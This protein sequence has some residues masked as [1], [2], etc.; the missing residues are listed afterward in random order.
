MPQPSLNVSEVV[1]EL[2]LNIFCQFLQLLVTIQIHYD[3]CLEKSTLLLHSLLYIIDTTDVMITLLPRL[4]LHVQESS[5]TT[6]GGYTVPPVSFPF[7][8][9]TSDVKNFTNMFKK[10]LFQSSAAQ[11]VAQL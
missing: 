7:V 2:L 10:I 11:T 1:L 6:F 5:K 9:I 8:F 4:T 3:L